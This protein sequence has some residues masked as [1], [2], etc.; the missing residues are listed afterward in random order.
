M[1]Q[2]I[3][4]TEGASRSFQDIAHQLETDA[5][6]GLAESEVGRRR[7]NHGYNEFEIAD[8]EPLWKKYLGQVGD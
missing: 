2:C 1:M 3:R 8:D 5:Q 6:V 4:A 7:K